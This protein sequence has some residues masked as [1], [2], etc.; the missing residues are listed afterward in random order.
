MQSLLD[1]CAHQIDLDPVMPDCGRV[2]MTM[3]VHIYKWQTDSGASRQT[4]S[5]WTLDQLNQDPSKISCGEYSGWWTGR[6]Q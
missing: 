1:M 3:G 2:R 4:A 6:F 5:S